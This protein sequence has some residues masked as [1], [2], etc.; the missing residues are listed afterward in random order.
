MAYCTASDVKTYLDITSTSDDTLLTALAARAQTM[1]DRYCHRTFEA[2]TD[3]D[4]YFDAIR[5]VDGAVLWLDAD[6]CSI[7]TVTNGDSSEIASTK[8]V[9]E[10]RNSGP[11]HAIRLLG[12]SG[13]SWTY[14][15]VPQNAITITGKW[16]YSATA[17]ADVVHAAILLTAHLY[18]L[19]D[20]T[21][22]M[23]RTQVSADGTVLLPMSWP[24]LV[25]DLL[26][27]Y[28]GVS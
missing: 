7:T 14:S 16:A 25:R 3:S 23:T 26:S 4:R 24:R 28:R 8:Y 6:L 19:R 5:D 27:P 11:Y 9:T 13:E 18:Q 12:N 15:D 2:S 21:P 20:S 17:P 1:I 10:P 22:E